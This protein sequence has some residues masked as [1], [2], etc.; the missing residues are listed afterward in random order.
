MTKRIRGVL[1]YAATALLALA[2]ACGSDNNNS[3]TDGGNQND[4]GTP[5][6]SGALTTA[7][8]VANGAAFSL[9][10]DSA[11]SPDGKTIYFTGVAP[12]TA[13]TASAPA[14]FKV[15]A[16]GGTTTVLAT[17]GSIGAPFGIA[18][19]SD[20]NTVYVADPAFTTT[21]DKGSIFS[22][23]ASGGTPTALTETSDYAPT[24]IAVAKVGGAD[25][26]VF[27]GTDKTTGF[28]SVFK[29]VGGTVST[30][31]AGTASASVGA[32][33]IYT[34]GTVY[35]TDGAGHVYS[36]AAGATTG[37][38][39]TPNAFSLGFPAGLAVSQDGK[40][41]LVANTDPATGGE[42]IARIAITGGAVTQLALSL[43]ANGE[44]G[45]LHRAADADVYS[46]VDTGAQST[47]AVYILR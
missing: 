42:G 17:G 18:V 10:L 12:G 3:N 24:A 23:S 22:V 19:S 13:T 47:G 8:V 33:S 29:D 34:D 32:V 36:A 7:A 44:A 38:L 4:A 16:S 15:A 28:S 2:A 21:N 41:L 20:G 45:G 26:I 27:V 9:P 46:F 30:V 1:P 35:F 5:L 11:P 40:F 25:N 43:T 14:I 6:G 37:T 31:I 39:V